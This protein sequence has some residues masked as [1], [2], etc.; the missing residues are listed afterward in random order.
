MAFQ[1]ARI[2][3]E[4]VTLRHQGLLSVTRIRP[5]RLLG[6]C[7]PARR[8]IVSAGAVEWP[9]RTDSLLEQQVMPG[10]TPDGPR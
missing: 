4:L 7:V 2:C 1:S 6:S 8:R 3:F 9:P 5:G 10:S